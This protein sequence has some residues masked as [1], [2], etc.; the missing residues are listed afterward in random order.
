MAV[1]ATGSTPTLTSAGIGSGLDV[2]GLVS[3]LMTVESLPLTALTNKTASYQASLT[4]YGSLQGALSSLQTAA[5]AMST[6]AKLT[7]FSTTVADTTIFA[8][9]A[10]SSASAGSHNITV[11][12]LAQAQSVRTA[13]GVTSATSFALGSVTLDFGTYGTGATVVGGVPTSTTQIASG[14]LLINGVDITT[15]V[16][17]TDVVDQ[18]AKIADA[19]NAAKIPNVTAAADPLTGK[20]SLT[21]A[22]S[23]AIA[24][25][26]TDTASSGF[27]VGTNNAFATNTFAADS[28]RS[29]TLTID[30]SNNTLQGMRDTI[31]GANFGVT[32]SIVT[33]TDGSHLVVSSNSSG[34]ANALRITVSQLGGTPTGSAALTSL[35]YDASGVAPS[36]MTSLATGQDASLTVDG[37]AVN[38]ASNVVTSAIQGMTLNLSKAGT[39][40]LGVAK[41]V[42]TAYSAIQTFVSAYNAVNTQIKTSTAFDATTGTASVLTGDA[43]TR[44]IQAQLR[45]ILNQAVSGAPSGSSTLSDFGI[46]FQKDGSLAVDSTKLSTA[47]NNPN[48]DVTKLF[49]SGGL[50]VQI[51]TSITS[52]LN[53]GGL[54]AG[55]TAGISTSMQAITKQSAALQVRLATIQKNYLAQFNALDTMLSSMSSTSSYLTQQFT[56]MAAITNQTKA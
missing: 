38:S 9:S 41:S 30:S 44:T 18:G 11:T 46:S 29:K 37:L 25:T 32:A 45:N 48:K 13:T 35:A 43:T 54:L 22:N 5:Q 7:A 21:S 23:T 27:S 4:A 15:T 10:D 26:G 2:N 8:A 34:A 52:M 40:T 42:S 20:V 1:T 31:N 53:T 28:T 14:S 16:D 19:I 39:T 24:I 6:T 36:A 49:A 51:N 50:A 56:S 47:L 17:G 12:S 55:R 33:G 3:K